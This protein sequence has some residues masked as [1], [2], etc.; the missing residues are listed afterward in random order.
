MKS[1]V[2]AGLLTVSAI[3]CCGLTGCAADTSSASGEDP[4]VVEGDVKASTLAGTYVNPA[5]ENDD[6]AFYALTLNADHTYTAQ[7]GCRQ[8]G[9]GVHCFAMTS[10]HGTWTTKKSG[11]QLG[12]PG[13][14]QELVLTDSFAQKS[15]YFYALSGGTLSL[16]TTYRGAASL[17]EKTTVAPVAS[18]PD[19]TYTDDGADALPFYTVTFDSDHTFKA[20][21]GCRQTTGVHCGAISVMSGT[22]STQKSGPQLGAPGGAAELV[23]IDSF[24]QKSTYFFTLSG[25]SLSLSSTYRG[26][27]SVFVSK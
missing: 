11:P 22:W 7:G 13:G 24:D 2:A 16:S 1:L 5:S 14:A 27:A 19:G 23:L 4:G 26:T 12:A 21:G 25:K 9:P 6:L 18:V 15:S 20:Q 8:D 17:F 3:L 10:F